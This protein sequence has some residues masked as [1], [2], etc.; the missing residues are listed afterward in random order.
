VFAGT[1]ATG[2]GVFKADQKNRITSVVSPGEAA[3]GGGSFDAAGG[4]AFWVNQAGDVAFTAHVAG[5]ET[6]ISNL[7]VKHA[8]TGTIMS[9]AHA[10][11]PAPRGGAFRSAYSPVLNDA[12]DVVFLGDLSSPPDFFQALGVYLYSGGTTLAVAR[13]GDP[14]P[15]GGKC[16]RASF[17]TAEQVHVNNAGEVALNALLD[18]VNGDGTPDTGLYVWSHGSLRVVARTGTVISGVGTVSQLA[19]VVMT[20]GPPPIS[21]LPDSGASNN[22]H[23]QVLFGATLTDGRAVLLLATPRS[24]SN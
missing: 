18:T 11:D 4:R 3:P 24:D 8:G 20:G 1:V 13:P 2:L 21:L 23:G 5:Q 22:D 9:I 14:M 16:V 7:Y 17:F 19:M 12:G 15:G 10:G 6:D